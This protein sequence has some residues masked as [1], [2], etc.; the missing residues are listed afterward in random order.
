MK[1]RR[2]RRRESIV[3]G[4]YVHLSTVLHGSIKIDLKLVHV[5]CSL[6][7]Q[8]TLIIMWFAIRRGRT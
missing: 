4:W 7:Y 6:L 5:L 8:E 1:T 2:S 3:L